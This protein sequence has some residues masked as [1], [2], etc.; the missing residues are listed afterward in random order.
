VIFKGC[1][2]NP[3]P[4]LQHSCIGNFM[5]MFYLITI[6]QH[7]SHETCPLIT[8]LKISC[9]FATNLFFKDLYLH[10]RWGEISDSKSSCQI[11]SFFYT[12]FMIV[13][14]HVKFLFFHQIFDSKSSCQISSFFTKFLIVKA[15]VKFL[16]FSP[17]F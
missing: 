7:Q 13:K 8:S 16:V 9:K 10:I 2:H 17:N 5:P 11:S 12:K 14:A 4:H 6:S 1:F 3:K 15:H